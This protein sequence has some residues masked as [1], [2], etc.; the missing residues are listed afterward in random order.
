MEFIDLK[1][2]YQTLKTEIDT[3]IQS[4][5]SS[6]QFIGGPYVAELE[7][8]LAAFVGRKHCLTCA[9]GTDSAIS[10]RTPTAWT[11]RAWSGRSELCWRREPILPRPS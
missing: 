3:N 11:R 5:L 8:P 1:A 10:H 9:N 6:A 4:V 2:Q 7:E